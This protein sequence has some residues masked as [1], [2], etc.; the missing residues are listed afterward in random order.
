MKKNNMKKNNMKKNRMFD[1]DS[2]QLILIACISIAVSLVMITIYEYSTLT[3]GEGSINRENIG[4]TYF[5]TN[6]RDRYINV[7][8][9]EYLNTSKSTNI[10]V[11]EKEMKKFAILHGYSIDFIRN[12]SSATIIF[13]D[14]DTKIIE[15]V[16]R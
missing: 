15:E 7:Y 1:D 11:F 5:Y 16:K 2:G 3:T 12:E 13:V 6:I 8:N 9:E 10:T 4:S 14:K